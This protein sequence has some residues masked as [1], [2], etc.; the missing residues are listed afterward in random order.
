L[1]TGKI[2]DIVPQK[3]ITIK[4][5][6]GNIQKRELSNVIKIKSEVK[7]KYFP[8][9]FYTNK[10]PFRTLVEL[11]KSMMYYSGFGAGLGSGTFLNPYQ[12][13]GIG[14]KLL[15]YGSINDTVFTQQSFYLDVRF[16]FIKKRLSPVVLTKIGYSVLFKSTSDSRTKMEGLMVGA[17]V[18]LQYIMKEGKTFQISVNYEKSQFFSRADIFLRLSYIFQLERLN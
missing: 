2:I 7:S 4:T 8:V 17:G 14:Y 1:L 5:D 16:P 3:T 12:Y 6:D 10:L 11:D 18:G 15:T 13:M 9:S